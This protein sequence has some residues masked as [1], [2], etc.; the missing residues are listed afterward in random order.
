MR[1]KTLWYDYIKL[2]CPS[3]RPMWDQNLPDTTHLAFPTVTIPKEQFKE[4]S[5]NYKILGEFVAEVLGDK[6]FSYLDIGKWYVEREYNE[7]RSSA[8]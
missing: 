1:I 8:K 7:S 2:H 5:N 3:S 4:W 6:D